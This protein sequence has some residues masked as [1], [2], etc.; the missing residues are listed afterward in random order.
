MITFRNLKDKE[1]ITVYKQNSTNVFHA[2]KAIVRKVDPSKTFLGDCMQITL[3]NKNDKPITGNFFSTWWP[4]R[5]NELDCTEKGGLYLNEEK[6]RKN[7]KAIIK[8][9]IVTRSVVQL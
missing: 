4:I 2:R 7:P 1:I 3:L 5:E 8:E 6:V 9:I